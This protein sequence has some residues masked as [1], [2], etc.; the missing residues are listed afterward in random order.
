MIVMILYILVIVVWALLSLVAMAITALIDLLI[1]GGERRLTLKIS[2]VVAR[3]IYRLSPAWKVRIEGRENFPTD[4]RPYVITA[5][6]QSFFDIPLMFFIPPHNGFNFVSKVEV[7]KIPAIGWML[8]LRND[9]V[10][11]RGTTKAA[12]AVM[13]Q[14]T[15]H[16]KGGTS[17]VIFPEGTR[18]KDGQVHLFKEGAFR[19]A[20]ECG[21]DIVPCVLD[22]TPNLLTKRGLKRSIL[23]LRI[24]P[25]IKAEQIEGQ[26]PREVAQRVQQLTAEA[27]ADLRERV[28]Q[29]TDK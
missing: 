12:A 4:G 10:I 7:R 6:H 16:L 25:T 24:L 3:M 23:T 17:V 27:L 19:L 22:G 5:N 1:G 15:K 13:E 26:N 21:V 29:P 20:Q 11:Q 14:G 18:S 28:K 2:Y 9:I 8:G